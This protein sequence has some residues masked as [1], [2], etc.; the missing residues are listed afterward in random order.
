M[1]VATLKYS[2]NEDQDGMKINSKEDNYNVEDLSIEYFI[3]DNKD[4]T[5][6]GSEIDIDETVKVIES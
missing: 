3:V 6:E 2:V 5:N 1:L 4:S